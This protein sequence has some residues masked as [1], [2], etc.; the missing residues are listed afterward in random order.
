M[1]ASA[2]VLAL[3][4]DD[5]LAEKVYSI[6]PTVE[7]WE[8]ELYGVMEIKTKAEL[9]GDEMKALTDWCIGQ[10]SDGWGEGFE[11]REI[12]TG[13]GDIYVSFWQ[14]GKDYFLKP[15]QEFKAEPELEQHHGL[16]MGGM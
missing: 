3:Y 12:R 13:G 15:E 6:N 11:Q 5:D 9:T 7:I 14:A 10:F 1:G 16:T 2:S 4:L 8:N